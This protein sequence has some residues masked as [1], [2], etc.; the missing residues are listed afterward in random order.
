MLQGINKKHKRRRET[1]LSHGLN[2]QGII[3]FGSKKPQSL[4]IR[5]CGYF[6]WSHLDSNQ[7]PPD[8][9]S[10]ALTS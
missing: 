10:G 4:F 3:G 9:E 1:N 6:V 2:N 8:Y 7:G 5:N